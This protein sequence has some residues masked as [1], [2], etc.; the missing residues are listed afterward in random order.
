MNQPALNF[1][2]TSFF[3]LNIHVAMRHLGASAI[4]FELT[5]FH[6]CELLPCYLNQLTVSNRATREYPVKYLN[7]CYLML[8]NVFR[9]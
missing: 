8:T 1:Q 7:L 5:I 3:H 9:G 6:P 4:C 2:L